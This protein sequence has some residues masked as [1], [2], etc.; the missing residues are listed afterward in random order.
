MRR[1]L[2]L[3][4]LVT[5][6]MRSLVPAGFML[7]PVGGEMTVA[8]CTGHGLQTINLDADG[9][10][11]PEKPQRSDSGFCPY[12]SGGAV[13]LTDAIPVPLAQQIRY[14]ELSYR[15]T[16]DLLRTATRVRATSARGPPL[17]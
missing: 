6:A 11:V 3:L 1:F 4:L 16:R 17:A 10:P 7:A 13:A 9:K 14:A 5:L 15:I 12:A 8:I 2:V